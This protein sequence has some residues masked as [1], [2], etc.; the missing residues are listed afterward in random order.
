MASVHSDPAW[1]ARCVEKVTSAFW[2]RAELS[3]L[4]TPTDMVAEE[5]SDVKTSSSLALEQSRQRYDGIACQ[6]L[7]LSEI[8]ALQRQR[9][10]DADRR[11]L[12]RDEPLAF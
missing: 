12:I 2:R 3:T 9:Q 5:P 8:L 7:I 4:S 1:A 10:D 11:A 6:S